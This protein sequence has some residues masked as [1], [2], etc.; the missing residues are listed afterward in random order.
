MFIK[1]I[2]SYFEREKTPFSILDKDDPQFRDLHRTM[3]SVSSE[4]HKKGI[5]TE[6]KRAAVI[7]TEEEDALWA[8]GSLETSTRLS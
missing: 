5:G 7:A 6:H 4:L 8:A 1:W 3:D 2:K